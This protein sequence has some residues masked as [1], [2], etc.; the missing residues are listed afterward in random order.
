[1][2]A[3]FLFKLIAA[4]GGIGWF[5]LI[6]LSPFWKKV[7]YFVI[8]LVVAVL[9]V[10]YTFLNF[11]HIGD[12]GGPT[13]FLSYD[14]V[15]KVFG[16]PYLVDGAWAHILAVDLLM[17]VWMKNSAAKSGINYWLMI[18]VFLLT[19]MFAPLGFLVFQ[20]IR[21]MKTKAYFVDVTS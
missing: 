2:S 17:A 6:L 9:A 12:A 14:G 21:W 16:N 5:S 15:I 1:M 19:M 10:F 20:L 18:P 3:E 7:D 4:I 8:G 13:A 11:G